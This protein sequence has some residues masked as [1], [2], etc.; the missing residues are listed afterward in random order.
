[1]SWILGWTITNIISQGGSLS[2]LYNIVNDIETR[3]LDIESYTMDDLANIL[4]TVIRDV[5]ISSDWGMT[6]NPQTGT[7]YTLLLTDAKNMVTLDNADPITLTVPTDTVWFPDGAYVNITQ[8]WAGQVTVE[9]DT[10][11]TVNSYSGM[12]NLAGQYAGATLLKTG[13]N[14]WLLVGNLSA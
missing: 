5:Q 1:M 3:T 4:A 6:L 13:T 9:W 12:L 10:G 2:D 8:I 7:T 11:V 14:E